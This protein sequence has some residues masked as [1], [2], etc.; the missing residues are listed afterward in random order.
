MGWVGR[1]AALGTAVLIQ[2]I[3]FPGSYTPHSCSLGLWVIPVLRP[4]GYEKVRIPPVQLL[5][6]TLTY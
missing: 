2:T 1:G 4:S 5:A 3:L 6:H